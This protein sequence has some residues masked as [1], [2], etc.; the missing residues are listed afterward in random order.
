MRV[1]CSSVV[2]LTVMVVLASTTVAHHSVSGQ[3]DLSKSLTLTGIIA[4]VEW[5]NPHAY[6]HL[7]VNDA[8]G[9]V[10][11]WALATVPLAMM[12][13]A[14]LTKETLSLPDRSPRRATDRTTRI[15]ARQ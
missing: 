12:H 10:T 6:V 9:K 8:N 7:D 15:L 1:R 5:I 2:V 13:K 11:T 14:G 4:K 3:Y